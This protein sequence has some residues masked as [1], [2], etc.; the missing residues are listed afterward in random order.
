MKYASEY[1][2]SK[3][4]KSLAEVARRSKQSAQTLHNWFHNKPELFAIVVDGCV[5]RRELE[6]K[7]AN[8][9]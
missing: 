9:D 3:G 6:R 1:C 7:N 4:L 8:K 5:W 2:K